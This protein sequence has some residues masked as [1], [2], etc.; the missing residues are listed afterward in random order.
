LL[1]WAEVVICMAPVY[2]K[3]VESQWP[4]YLSKV[5]VWTIKDPHF[6]KG[7]E[8]HR[9]VVSQIRYKIEERFHP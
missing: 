3:K 9:E 6:S 8:I 5:E 4:Q 7:T 2:R 1:N